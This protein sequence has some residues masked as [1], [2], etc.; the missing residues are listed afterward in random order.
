M[1]GPED[2]LAAAHQRIE[3]LEASVLAAQ[4]EL[5]FFV[6]AAG[7]DLQQPLRA[8]GT[9]A[10]LLQREFRDHEHA[11][12]FTKVIVEG[13]AQINALLA[14]LLAYSRS[15][16]V[17]NPVTLD[18]NGPL[19]WALLN[20]AEAIEQSGAQVIARPLPRAF[21]DEQQMVAMFE[22]LIGN[23]IK[24]RGTDAPRVEITSDPGEEFHTISVLDNG[25]GI[26]SE[27]REKVFEPFK[28]L[29]G[30]EVPGSGLGLSICRKIARAHGGR[31]WIENSVDPGTIV[32]FTVPV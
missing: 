10:Q 13:V 12:E 24:F 7:H 29:H 3:E 15:G 25:C 22:N 19:Q 9:Y 30:R 14:D 23:S 8:I 1:S 27:Y 16:N 2:P 18:L 5:Q 26:D 31:T 17:A 11:S 32:R 20:L 28:R 4:N 21:A 6:Y